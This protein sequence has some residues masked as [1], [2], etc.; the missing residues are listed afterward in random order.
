MKLLNTYKRMKKKYGVGAVESIGTVCAG[1][2]ETEY[3]FY[4]EDKDRKE[5]TVN[6]PTIDKSTL[7]N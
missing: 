3:I 1:N 4:I 2:R 6:I 7:W 5:M